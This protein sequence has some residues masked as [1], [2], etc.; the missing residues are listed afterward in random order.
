MTRHQPD[1]NT[2][3]QSNV[4]THITQKVIVAKGQ[5]TQVT[6]TLD[7]SKKAQEEK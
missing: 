6:M 2:P 3:S 5:D 7:L 1:P 4:T